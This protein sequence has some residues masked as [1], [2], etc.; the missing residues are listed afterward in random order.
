[1]LHLYT[2][3]FNSKLSISTQQTQHHGLTDVFFHNGEK[4]ILN[5]L[6]LHKWE[7]T[8]WFSPLNEIPDLCISRKKF[9]LLVFYSLYHNKRI[10]E[11]WDNDC[12]WIC[13]IKLNENSS[14]FINQSNWWRSR[15]LYMGY[16]GMINW[17]QNT[18][19]NSEIKQFH[20]RVH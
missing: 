4:N 8:L 5:H 11:E 15:I 2:I 14:Y 7:I 19:M 17:P 13:E 12:W 18:H 6:L 9:S 3:Y 1:M 20:F 16:R 10:S